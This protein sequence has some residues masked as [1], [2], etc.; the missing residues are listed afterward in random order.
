[1]PRLTAARRQPALVGRP[2]QTPHHA[3]SLRRR[4]SSWCDT[5]KREDQTAR[6]ATSV[7]LK[8]RRAYATNNL[9]AAGGVNHSTRRDVDRPVR[10]KRAKP[11][12]AAR[13]RYGFNDARGEE[14]A[15]P[16]GFPHPLL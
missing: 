11:G 15:N 13:G 8:Q 4:Q 14:R 16:R 6:R 7:L 10:S 3:H 5:P 12:D 1:E 9:R 2:T